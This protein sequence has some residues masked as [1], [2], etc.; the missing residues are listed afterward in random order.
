MGQGK[1]T[2]GPSDFLDYTRREERTL[3]KGCSKTDMRE[4]YF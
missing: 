4:E 3:K 1:G 2:N